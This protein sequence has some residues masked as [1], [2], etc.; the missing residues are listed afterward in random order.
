MEGQ[1]PQRIKQARYNK[2]MR[3]QQRIAREI[4]EAQIGKRQL[5]LVDQPL[6]ARS[7]ADAPDVDGRVLLPEPAPV[8]E[9]IEV[10][11]TGTQVYDLLARRV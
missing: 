9:L 3:V 1:I 11:I 6:V 8:G 5:V 7:T 10:E 4:S 2:A